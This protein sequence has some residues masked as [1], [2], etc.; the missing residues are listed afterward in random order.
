MGEV[1]RSSEPSAEVDAAV[2][3]VTHAAHPA[4]ATYAAPTHVTHA[5]P[6]THATYAAH[7]THSGAAAPLVVGSDLAEADCAELL[8]ELEEL[9]A[10]VAA[11][12]ARLAVHLD[13][14]ARIRQERAGLSAQRRGVGVAAQ[15]GLARRVSPTRG[16]QLLGMA[17]ALV[18][19]MPHTH[20]A[21]TRG[22]LSEW[23]ATLLVR[24]SAC[25]T[26]EDRAT[27]DEQICADPD[28]F[29]GWGDRRL[30]AESRRLTARLDAAALARRARTA[31]SERRVTIRP[32]PDTMAVL[33]APLPVAQ[34]V[35]V[36]AE[37]GRAADTARATGDSRTRGQI[38]ADTL[39]ERVTGQSTAQG[40]PIEIQLV[41]TD[42]A[43]FDG[44]DEPVL[45]PEHGRVPA[46]WARE[47]VRAAL[48]DSRSAGSGSPEGNSTGVWM[49]RLFTD[50]SGRQLIAMESRAR[51]A[52]A[53]LARF[54]RVRDGTCRTPWCDA[55]IRHT[56]HVVAYAMGG[57]TAAENLQGLCEACN[58][59]KQAPGWRGDV[60]EMPTATGSTERVPESVGEGVAESVGE[61]AST[62]KQI[63]T[64]TPTGHRYRSR[65]PDLPGVP[66]PRSTVRGLE[67]AMADLIRADRDGADQMRSD[68]TGLDATVLV[69]NCPWVRRSVR[70][71][72][73]AS[74][75][76]FDL[77]VPAA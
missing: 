43:V 23:R 6:A 33:T 77:L 48:N 51:R 53:G 2:T 25:L 42:R 30:V 56:D 17:K 66:A 71:G 3:H 28:R 61:W 11:A 75:G 45:V 5:A 68:L 21:L 36:Y 16:A 31:E 29:E 27:F 10:A 50:P 60:E 22:Q 54:I 44:D 1:G 15:V 37:L 73:T 58:Y 46:P 34:G 49:R 32:A 8:R 57:P 40:P 20:A 62:E 41:M 38:M 67:Q 52:P 72:R 74:A 19:E 59:A 47:L 4:P 39:V 76:S 70:I 64:T 14:M 9:N 65:A 55:P 26:R 35:A 12:Q 69:P 24:E 63:L 18:N 7:P 13:R